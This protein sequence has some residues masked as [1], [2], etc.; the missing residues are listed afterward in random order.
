MARN[1]DGTLD[2][3]CVTLLGDVVHTAQRVANDG[4]DARKISFATD[5][6]PLFR[7][8]DVSEMKPKGIDLSSYADVKLNAASIYQTVQQ[9]SMPCNLDEQGNVD[10]YARWS[11]GRVALFKQWMDDG[12]QS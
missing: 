6:R 5:I 3:F 7:N 10:L 12:M 11:A 8:Y 2:V 1:E 9:G 4:W